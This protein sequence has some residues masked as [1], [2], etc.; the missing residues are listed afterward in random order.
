[1]TAPLDSLTGEYCS[2]SPVVCHHIH[3]H[4][5][6]HT[7]VTERSDTGQPLLLFLHH[8]GGHFR[9]IDMSF[10]T[11]FKQVRA[12]RTTH[13]HTHTHTHEG[14]NTAPNLYKQQM[15]RF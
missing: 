15:N 2:F 14:Y 1:M 11:P 6:K 8:P 12:K 3:R 5:H 10:L 13:T 9:A 4:L 7:V